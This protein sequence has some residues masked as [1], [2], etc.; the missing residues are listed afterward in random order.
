[1]PTGY[2]K[3]KSW[4]PNPASDYVHNTRRTK[5]DCDLR[6]EAREPKRDL[7]VCV[8]VVGFLGFKITK[9][10]K[11]AHVIIQLTCYYNYKRIQIKKFHHWKSDWDDKD[12]V[13]KPNGLDFKTRYHILMYKKKLIG[14]L[15]IGGSKSLVVISF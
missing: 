10:L 6:W 15:Q 5:K 1:M 3:M 7:E 8:Y 14:L 13:L 2:G 4:S 11:F 12:I 9:Y